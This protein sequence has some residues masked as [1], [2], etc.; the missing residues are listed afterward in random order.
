VVHGA[1][2][3]VERN[4]FDYNRHAMEAA[5]NAG[6]G[7]FF[8]DNLILPHGGVDTSFIQTHQIDRHGSSCLGLECGRA[9]EYSDVEFNT[10]W[11]TAGNAV[12]LRGTPEM[13]TSG[14]KVGMDVFH[15]AFSHSALWQGAPQPLDAAAALNQTET[16]L[17]QADNQ[18]E[19]P[20]G[21]TL[22]NIGDLD[23]DG[24]A[25]P[26]TATG[27]TWWYRSSLLGRYVFLNRSTNLHPSKQAIMNSLHGPLNGAEA[28][29]TRADGRV[30]LFAIDSAY[31]V[32]HRW[33]TTPGGSQWTAWTQLDGDMTALA[34]ARRTDGRVDLYGVGL[35]GRI[36]H[37]IEDPA[38]GGTSADSYG[39][40][41]QLGLPTPSTVM[42]RIAVAPQ[43][44]GKM[45]LAA[46]D[47]AG[48]AHATT[49]SA[50]GSQDF[51]PWLSGTPGYAAVALARNQDGTLV[52]YFLDRTGGLTPDV[53]WSGTLSWSKQTSPNSGTWTAPA[54]LGGTNVVALHTASHA[55]G[56]IEL[57]VVRDDGRVFLTHQ[58]GPNASTYIQWQTGA[59]TAM[60]RVASTTDA[61][62]LI[63]FFPIDADG[64]LYPRGQMA[65]NS[66]QFNY[67]MPL[68]DNLAQQ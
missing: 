14:D 42:A 20:V 49:Q 50:V 62:H 53:V 38:S 13:L 10:V 33:Q 58:T 23:G 1:Y 55:D 12:K 57:V 41:L 8:Y 11:Y 46:I 4:V 54:L 9:G 48:Q 60:Q 39:S 43:Q 30:E 37:R 7:Y 51:T 22:T 29:V 63:E 65:P 67:A 66:D 17:T 18:I 5:G 21:G 24:T 25:D 68:N 59:D 34:A 19:A 6:T 52:T 45:V 26:V 28:A 44:D 16:G 35:D 36:S 61:N 47:T 2:A 3:W 32:Q 31:H 56:R 40:W 64:A 15:N 27:V